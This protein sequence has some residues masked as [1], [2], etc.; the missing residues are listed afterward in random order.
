[1][2]LAGAR[3]L[4]NLHDRLAARSIS[5]HIVGAHGTVRDLLRAE[6]IDEKVGGLHRSLT[7]DA[8]LARKLNQPS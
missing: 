6:G 7:L 8:L 5:F 3:M 1:V 2:D 4:H